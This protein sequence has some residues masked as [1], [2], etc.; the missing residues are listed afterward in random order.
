MKLM[1]WAIAL[2]AAALT[3][4]AA[5]AQGTEAAAPATATPAAPAPAG[6]PA[7]AAS[8]PTPAATPATPAIDHV[9]PTPGIGVPDGRMGIQDQVTEIGQQAAGFHN[10]WL[11][12]LCVIISLFVLALLVYTIVRYRRGANPTP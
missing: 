2:A 8:A 6:V 12:T 1:G 9:A 10:N 4:V 5:V 3:P 7:D 11:L